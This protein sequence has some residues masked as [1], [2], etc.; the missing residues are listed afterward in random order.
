MKIST[1]LSMQPYFRK[2]IWSKNVNVRKSR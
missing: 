1:V 2:R